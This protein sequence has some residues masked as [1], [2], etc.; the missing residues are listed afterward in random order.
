MNLTH[1]DLRTSLLSGLL[2][3]ISLCGCTRNESGLPGNRGIRP[4]SSFE[5]LQNGFPDPD[6]IYGPFAFWFW[7]TRLDTSHVAEMARSMCQV[8][9]NPGYAHPRHGLPHDEWL[10]PLWFQSMEAALDVARPAGM[11]LGFCDEYW[12]PSGRADGKVLSQQPDLQAISLKWECL[13]VNEGRTVEIPASFF[14]VAARLDTSGED[15]ADVLLSNTLKV[16]GEGEAFTWTAPEGYWKVFIFHQYFHP[17]W[18]GGD[19]NYLD[20]RLA[21]EFIE[22]A[23]KPYRKL[24]DKF[25]KSIPGVFVDHEGDYGWKLAWSADLEN[26]YQEKTGR[27]IRKMI[28]LMIDK[29]KQGT[30]VRARHDWYDVV[31]DI[32]A[33]DFFGVVS[34]YLDSLGMYA[35]SNLWEES[36]FLQAATLG[37]A[38]KAHRA[39]SMPG[40]DCLFEKGLQVHDFKEIQSITEFEGRRFQSEV[41]GAQGWQMTPLL[42]KQVANSVICWGVSHVVPHGINLNRALDSIPYPAD[43]Y[44][45]NP[46]WPYLKQ[47]NDFVRRASYINSHG[48]TA[49]DVLL[50]N[51]MG[52]IWPLLGGPIFHDTLPSQ[53]YRNLNNFTQLDDFRE[54]RDIDHSYSSLINELTDR[55]IE[56][57]IADEYYLQQMRVTKDGGLLA[58]NHQFTSIVLPDMFCLERKTAEILLNFLKN[59]G[60]VYYYKELPSA[61]AENGL[62]DPEFQS[63]VE[64]IRKMS[65]Q[66]TVAPDHFQSQIAFETGSF[67]MTQLHRIID[68]RHFFWLVNNTGEYRDC[69]LKIKGLGGRASK[70]DCEKGSIQVLASENNPDGSIVPLT[71][72]P[73]EAFWLVLEEDQAP[74]AD[75]PSKVSKVAVLRLEGDWTVGINA[76][77]QPEPFK[78][79]V[80]FPGYAAMTSGIHTLTPW[81][82]WGLKYFTGY[83]DYENDFV[84]ETVETGK[85]YMIDLGAVNHTA[86]VWINGKN[87]G[88]KMWP[89]FEFDITNLVVEGDNNVL[90]RVGNT[91]YNVMRYYYDEG[92]LH[93]TDF[94]TNRFP[95]PATIRSG[96]FGPVTVLLAE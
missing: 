71:F 18:D 11:Y 15:A 94:V 14:T 41:L 95:D 20:K 72:K 79:Q 21:R 62:Q 76:S 86:E 39:V 7:D 19:V 80:Q 53:V 74:S 9:L 48:F 26:D 4:V 6:M 88:G 92:R 67:Q 51:P 43:W 83:V 12:W 2:C 90:I 10:S 16:V 69:K 65:T 68:G 32:Y 70:W 33:D 23:H 59:G 63:I 42:M 87:A 56:Y 35:I 28:P 64:E 91:M 77:V 96:M 3:M 25:G 17:G 82:S 13:Y 60:A 52:S 30:W 84:L 45:S 5:D 57:L 75:G 46:Y 34:R 55:R 44:T 85:S 47:W 49:P 66:I 27:D 38:F 50:L 37:D 40:N 8:G 36:L 78:N 93:N 61:S 22:I 31:S 58:K 24:E 81:E 54:I 89:P 73:Y 1:I 29:D